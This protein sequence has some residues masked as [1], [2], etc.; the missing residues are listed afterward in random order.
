M[1]VPLSPEKFNGPWVP[2]NFR[3]G[4]TLPSPNT[5]HASAPDSW[6]LARRMLDTTVRGVKR[7]RPL[8]LGSV[9]RVLTRRMLLHDGTRSGTSA[10]KKTWYGPLVKIR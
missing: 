5:Q 10:N 7:Q 6:V 1:L 9:M 4:G 2:E 8:K 3:G